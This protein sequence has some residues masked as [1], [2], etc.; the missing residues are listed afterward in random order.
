MKR[1]IAMLLAM[2]TV[3][4][5]ASCGDNSNDDTKDSSSVSADDGI[6]DSADA[7]DEL[8]S[9]VQK[10]KENEEELQDAAEEVLE[11]NAAVEDAAILNEAQEAAIAEAKTAASDADEAESEEETDADTDTDTDTDTGDFEI[12]SVDDNVYTSNFSGITFTAPDGWSFSSEEEILQMMNLGSSVLS[13]KAQLYTEIAQQTTIYDMM[14]SNATTGDNVI[15]LYENLNAY[16][17]GVADAY[18]VDTYIDVLDSQM[19]SLAS[20]GITFEKKDS[21]KVT[22]SGREFSKVEF[23]TTYET[24]GY[25]AKQAYYIAKEGD[26]IIAVVSTLGQYSDEDDLSVFEEYFS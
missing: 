5:F 11:K 7:L 10:V 9:E 8:E 21:G 16:G 1:K 24:Y 2:L 13:D 6:D 23:D 3:C 14:A 19:E 4:S 12:G 17:S 15:V 22:L 26:Y 20:S 18:D 25:T